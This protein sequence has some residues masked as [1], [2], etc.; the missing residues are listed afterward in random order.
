MVSKSHKNTKNPGQI[1]VVKQIISKT[2]LVSQVLFNWLNFCQIKL[3]LMSVWKPVD[4]KWPKS[5]PKSKNCE[6]IFDQKLS[7]DS[8]VVSER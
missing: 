6:I 3:E 8:V 7:S 1:E 2:T 4:F 5:T